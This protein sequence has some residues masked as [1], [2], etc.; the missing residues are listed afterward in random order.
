MFAS[1]LDGLGNNNATGGAVALA[2]SEDSS[3]ESTLNDN[4]SKQEALIATQKTSLTAELSIANEIL[5]A[6]P[7]QINEVNEMY[8]AITGY[9]Q[10]QNG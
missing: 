7:E 4:I 1:A 10:N 6:I 8:S 9:K 3:Q 5:Q 2:L